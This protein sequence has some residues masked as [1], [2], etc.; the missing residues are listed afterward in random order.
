M[1]RPSFI[2]TKWGQMFRIHKKSGSWCAPLL[3]KEKGEAAPFKNQMDLYYIFLMTAIGLGLDFSEEGFNQ[4]MT[5]INRRYT[6]EF[7]SSIRYKIAGLFLVTELSSSSL[8]LNDKSIIKNKIEQIISKEDG[9]TFLNRDAIDK[10]NRY[11]YNGF[12]YLRDKLPV[13]PDP[14]NFL[15]WYYDEVMPDLFLD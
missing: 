5:D 14:H 11:A 13:A 1:I 2:K 7:D 4:N 6:Q 9:N 12:V 8:P 3:K 10:M 15:L